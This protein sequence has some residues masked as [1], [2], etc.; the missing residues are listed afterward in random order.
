MFNLNLSLND[1]EELYL[2]DI[3]NYILVKKEMLNAEV[4]LDIKIYV[5]EKDRFNL[6]IPLTIYNY[7]LNGINVESYIF[8]N[9]NIYDFCTGLKIKGNWRFYDDKNNDYGQTIRYYISNKG[10]TIYKS[11]GKD[12]IIVA[13]NATIFNEFESKKTYDVNHKYYIDI[14]QREI[15]E[16]ETKK[17]IA[18]KTGQLSLF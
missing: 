11:N 18:D 13:K 15:A 5:L 17:E 1:C 7:F 10:T 2:W 12:K 4:D 3:N 14:I 8:K 16:I 6:I 9:D